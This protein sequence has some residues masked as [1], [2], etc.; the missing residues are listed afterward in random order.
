ML[1]K[2]K[3]EESKMAQRSTY[4]CILTSEKLESVAAYTIKCLNDTT[5]IKNCVTSTLFEKKLHKWRVIMNNIIGRIEEIVAEQKSLL[6][7]YTTEKECCLKGKLNS[8]RPSKILA[9]MN[10]SEISPQVVERISQ[11]SDE[12][13]PHFGG[14][15][16]NRK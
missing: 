7:R 3:S 9:E 11:G 8:R 2:L 15:L 1:C 5:K 12:I 4:N 14:E 13:F 10:L 16:K 6:K